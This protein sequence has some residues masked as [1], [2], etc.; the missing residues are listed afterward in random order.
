MRKILALFLVS[1]LAMVALATGVSAALT[2]TPTTVSLG[3]VAVDGTTNAGTVTL[4]NA[5]TLTSDT[6]SAQWTPT[7]TG[8]LP[9][10]YTFTPLTLSTTANTATQIGVSVS[11]PGTTPLGSY[12][13]IVTA[14]ST[15][16]AT[17]SV[18]V[19]L[20]LTVIAQHD[21]SAG[22]NVTAD[23]TYENLED[24]ASTVT[25]TKSIEVKNNGASSET[26][27]LALV[28]P[29]K[30]GLTATFSETTF[31]LA[32]GATKTVTMTMIVPVTFNSGNNAAGSV[33]ASFNNGQTALTPVT[34]NV[35]SMVQIDDLD[36]EIGEEDESNVDDG[37]T[38][39]IEATP[40]DEVVLRFK[41]S[42]L[43]D[44]KYDD[45]DLDDTELTV[46][47]DDSNFGD[48]IDE[49]ANEFDINAGED[50]NDV[51]VRFTIPDDAEDGIYD[52]VIT[53]EAKQESGAVHTDT[54]TVGLEV[55]LE[56][57]DVRIVSIEPSSLSLRCNR[58]ATISVHV[59]NYGKDDQ[60]E[61]VINVDSSE[62]DINERF[63]GISLD[64]LGDRD[65]DIRREFRV[66][67]DD[68]PAGTYDV[69]VRVF[70]NGDDLMDDETL[71]I[72]LENCGTAPTPTTQP[73]T[74]VVVVPTTPTTPP[75]TPTGA[76]ITDIFDTIE[77]PFT[78]SPWFLVL[79][80]AGNVLVLGLI[81]YIVVKV[82][83]K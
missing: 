64:E 2:A 23:V 29:A 74:P 75:T 68:K 69:D 60:D 5:F 14:T 1:M 57:D 39:D 41:V 79:L 18:A 78:E 77:T 16:P 32:A 66:S 59:K 62:L 33:Q 9:G 83:M 4:L 76:S 11:V 25:V 26:V 80:V 12:S 67:L 47:I 22:T 35:K 36:V 40:E 34:L 71:S 15:A 27:A 8:N 10:T 72:E 24:R 28:N 3:T 81:V 37:D 6:A 49:D 70:I 65:N 82:A 17:G 45:G 19:T 54:I 53:V 58:D 63:T 52:M 7:L 50:S 73:T 55:N 21:V 43:F 61:V 20:T 56:N 30:A 44:D 51:E 13:G 46:T 48:D 38:I 31:T 42:N